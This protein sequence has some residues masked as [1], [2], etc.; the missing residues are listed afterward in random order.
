MRIVLPTAPRP[1]GAYSAVSRRAGLVMLSGQLPLERGVLTHVGQVGVDLT[2]AQGSAAARQAALNVIAHLV[3]LASIGDLIGLLRLDGYVAG[4]SDFTAQAEVLDG[5][6]QLLIDV[7]GEDVGRHARVALGVGRLP[8]NAP[9]E[10]GLS[11]VIKPRTS[12]GN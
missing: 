6:S 2:V 12:T 5:A 8:M 10:L 9:V 7:L 3:E 4:G 1:L 11:L